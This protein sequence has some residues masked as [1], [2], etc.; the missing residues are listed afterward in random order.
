[1]VK[2]RFPF[3]SAKEEFRAIQHKRQHKPF[4]QEHASYRL[5]FT[6]QDFLLREELRPIRLQLELLKS[7]MLLQEE[8]INSTIVVFGSARIPTPE[9]ANYNLKKA[10]AAYDKASTPENEQKLNYAQR[11]KALSNYYDEARNF[12]KLVSSTCQIGSSCNYV[13]TTG[14]GPG[15]MEAA[16]RGAHDVAAKTIGF[17]IAL[18]FEQEPNPYITPNLTFQFHYFAIRK[19]HFLLRARAMVAFPGGYG[20]LDE[21]FETLTL[22][23]TKKMD[24][25]PIILFGKAFW[26]KLINFEYLVEE[27]FIEA[28]DLKLFHFVET[29]EEAWQHIADFYEQEL[30]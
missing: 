21:L 1:M 14:G 7:E 28:E 22:L 11:K 9:Q 20:T 8:K 3:H 25:I 13:I 30:T 19:M 23:Q 2:R 5:A 6:D 18:P 15:I 10:Q 27:E 17:N 4:D 29:A 24:K 16:N 26:Q 12:G